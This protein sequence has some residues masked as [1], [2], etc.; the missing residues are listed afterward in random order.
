MHHP[1]G[2]AVRSCHVQQDSRTGTSAQLWRLATR[3]SLSRQCGWTCLSARL[4]SAIL[5]DSQL[6]L[7][8]P[9]ESTHSC[10]GMNLSGW[11]NQAATSCQRKEL[12]IIHG[13]SRGV[14]LTV[15]PE[16][17]QTPSQPAVFMQPAKEVPPTLLKPIFCA[18]DSGRCWGYTYRP[19]TAPAV[20]ELTYSQQ[21]QKYPKKSYL[22]TIPEPQRVGMG[23]GRHPRGVSLETQHPWG[24]PC[25]GMKLPLVER[26][27]PT[28]LSMAEKLCQEIVSL[29]NLRQDK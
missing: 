13:R 14:L 29:P 24:Q 20:K 10:K 28:P 15:L 2:C 18:K 6:C 26:A 25:S 19:H 1:S 11:G 8:L 4:T 17:F 5:P 27:Q 7:C 23:R 12:V 21:V 22:F 16:S 3:L 9:F